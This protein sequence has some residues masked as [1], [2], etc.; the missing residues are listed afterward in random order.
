MGKLRRSGNLKSHYSR[1]LHSNRHLRRGRQSCT[2]TPLRCLSFTSTSMILF[3][4]LNQRSTLACLNSCKP[5]ICSQWRIFSR[6]PLWMSNW[7]SSL[8]FQ[9]SSNSIWCSKTWDF[10]WNLKRKL[11]RIQPIKCQTDRSPSSQ[12]AEGVRQLTSSIYR[13][14][15]KMMKVMIFQWIWIQLN[16][17]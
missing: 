4:R 10:K 12:S 5:K 14:L 6:P 17:S 1:I 3:L 11:S 8:C 13:N 16:N 9:P 2:R 7:T 15:P